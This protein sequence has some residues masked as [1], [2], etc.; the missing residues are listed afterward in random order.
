[1]ISK[2]AQSIVSLYQDWSSK[3]ALNGDMELDE[4]RELFDQWGDLSSEPEGVEFTAATLGGV[5]GYWLFPAGC[6]KSRVVIC[7]HGGGFV[8]GSPKSHNK[9]YGHLAKAAGCAGFVID[10]TRAPENPHPGIVEQA[11]AVYKQLLD[12]GYKPEHIATT[13]DSAGGNLCT[14]MI[15]YA[16]HKGLPLPAC[17]APL[18]PWYDMEAKG[19]SMVTN[20]DK[21][22]LVGDNILEGM[23]AAF[24]GEKGSPQD[25]FANPL[26]ADLNGFPPTLV[27]VGEYETLLDDS[28]R[29]ADLAKAAG[30]D[31]ELQIF[32]EMQHV[33][34]FMAGNAPEAD[35]AIAKLA[36]F[37]KPRLGLA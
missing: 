2:E 23:V 30:V 1:M 32:P 8:V 29:F 9:M 18:S 35:D 36:S 22:A 14:T 3:L 27:Q 28:T 20:A 10:Y 26:F 21:D 6:D 5:D 4:L 25:P 31:I 34:Q 16:R 13:G 11:V 33:F 24:L 37:M 19:E 7:C 12:Q 15:L 17:C